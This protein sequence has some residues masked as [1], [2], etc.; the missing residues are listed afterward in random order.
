MSPNDLRP[1]YSELSLQKLSVK[2]GL[3]SFGLTISSYRI[4]RNHYG[5]DKVRQRQQIDIITVYKFITATRKNEL[6]NFLNNATLKITRKYYSL[7]IYPSD[8]WPNK[9]YK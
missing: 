5:C 9:E 3:R 6:L 1:T 7:I 8:I 2:V 4:Q